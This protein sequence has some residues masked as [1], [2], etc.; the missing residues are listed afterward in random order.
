MKIGAAVPLWNREKFIGAYLE[1]IMSYGITPIVALGERPWGDGNSDGGS[2][3]SLIPDR[4]EEILERYFPNVIVLKGVYQRHGDSLRV[5]H[6]ALKDFD[7]IIVNDCD[8]FM[9]DKTMRRFIELMGTAKESHIRVNHNTMIRE[10]YFDWRYGKNALPGGQYPIMAYKPA[11]AN[12]PK[13]M[14]RIDNAGDGYEWD[15]PEHVIHHFR[16]AKANGSGKRRCVEPESSQG[17]EQAPNDI[18]DLL[19]KWENK[20]CV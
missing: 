5:C 7:W 14:T 8:L 13:N 3:E 12:C 20:I 19:K 10:Y 18:V 15:E 16:F 1:Q 2:D 17:Y 9:D 11:R 4:S 6:E